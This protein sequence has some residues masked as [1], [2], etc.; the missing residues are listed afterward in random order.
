[1][2]FLK[3][4]LILLNTLVICMMG[5]TASAHPSVQVV[6]NVP[7]ETN[8]AVKGLRQTPQV[9]VA[10]INGAKKSIDLEE[11]YICNKSGEALEPV[12][13]ALR[14]AP[15]R[16]VAVRLLVDSKF[17][18]KYRSD[19]FDLISKPFI[20]VRVV[21]FSSSGGIQH[22]KYFI[23]DHSDSFVGSAN[24]DW[25]AL[26]H[27]HE[28]GLRIKDARIG[29]DLEGIFSKDWEMPCHFR[30]SYHCP[31]KKKIQNL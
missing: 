3:T 6:Q 15:S 21:D 23:V 27:V 12:L 18:K 9:W 11:F 31:L 2:T 14:A 29:S 4:S 7:I 10:M 1:M 19:V 13:A 8:L 25:V 22:S 5:L 17:F 30:A 28:V 16:G 26:T 24:F 20:Q